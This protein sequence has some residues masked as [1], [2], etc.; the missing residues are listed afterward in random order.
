MQVVESRHAQVADFQHVAKPARRDQR[1]ARALALQDR[2]RGDR[3]RVQHLARHR[4]PS[5]ARPARRRCP[6]CSRPAWRRVLCVRTAPSGAMATRS[7][8]V[9][10]ISIADA[11]AH[12]RAP[13]NG[14]QATSGACAPA[15]A[16]PLR[17]MPAS[18]PRRSPADRPARPRRNRAPRRR[19][20]PARRA[21]PSPPDP[22]PAPA[23]APAAG[24]GHFVAEHLAPRQRHGELRRQFV[25][26]IERIAARRARAAALQPV[27][28]V[29]A[30]VRAHL[31]NALIAPASARC[32][33][34][35][36]RRG[37]C[38]ARRCP[39]R[40]RNPAPPADSPPRSPRC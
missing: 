32:A 38:R 20:S 2:V 15:G 18:P 7:V 26:P 36:R 13:S 8:K 3:G 11:Q 34:A 6:R 27:R 24:A 14:C 9:P 21:N 17:A 10:P 12:A 4:S 30:P 16:Q 5:A 40:I 37:T 31:Q 29:R 23:A 35:P 19:S 33:A 28:P 39:A 1:G 22:A 25:S